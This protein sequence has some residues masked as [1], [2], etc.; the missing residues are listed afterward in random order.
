MQCVRQDYRQFL[1]CQDL[2][3][4]RS[5]TGSTHFITAHQ[6]SINSSLLAPGYEIGLLLL[7]Q[8]LAHHPSGH[9]ALILDYSGF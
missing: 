1:P 6:V 9:R 3:R 7:R 4:N 2:Q 8:F 5:S